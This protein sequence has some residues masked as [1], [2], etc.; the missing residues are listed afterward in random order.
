MNQ[1]SCGGLPSAVSPRFGHVGYMPQEI[2]RHV[3]KGGQLI[4]FWSLILGYVLPSGSQ[5]TGCASTMKFEDGQLGYRIREDGSQV[6]LRRSE[7]QV[8]DSRHLFNDNQKNLTKIEKKLFN[9]FEDQDLL[10]VPSPACDSC[11]GCQICANP[12]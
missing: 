11:R 12:F 2:G 8:Q 9:Q 4:L 7:T 3:D 5:C 10:H 1:L 6:S